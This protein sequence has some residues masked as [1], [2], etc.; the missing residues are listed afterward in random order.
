MRSEGNPS[1]V[2]VQV[3]VKSVAIPTGPARVVSLSSS[4]R[5][6]GAYGWPLNREP[7]L[8]AALALPADVHYC[9]F[10]CTKAEAGDRVL[11][12][13]T[14]G[15][16]RQPTGDLQMACCSG[17]ETGSFA[18]M[19]HTPARQLQRRKMRLLIST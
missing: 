4:S 17:S 3:L 10:R 12:N 13:G 14:V 18:G 9:P 2:G 19:V 5:R 6:Q 7:G 8:E 11:T 1:F 15:P 16:G